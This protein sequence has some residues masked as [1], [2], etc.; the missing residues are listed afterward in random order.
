MNEQT[1]IDYSQIEVG[2]EFPPGNYKL[3]NSTVSAFLSA[4]ENDSQIYKDTSLV[5]P[6][7]VAARAFG[8]LSSIISLPPGSIHV[9]QELEFIGV[10]KA[11]ENLTSYAKISRTQRRG[12]LHLLTVDLNVQNQDQET[13]LNGKT[14]F[15]LPRRDDE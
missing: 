14:S 7:I 6:M 11:G 12:K 13:V 1:D 15:I 8:T 5:P 4:V 2:F 9:S 3:N 10:V